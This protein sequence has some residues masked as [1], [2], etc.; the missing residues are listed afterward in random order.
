MRRKLDEKA[1][2]QR[3][4]ERAQVSL[5]MWQCCCVREN[6]WTNRAGGRAGVSVQEY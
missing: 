6:L 4:E 1:K 3:L 2:K 5:G